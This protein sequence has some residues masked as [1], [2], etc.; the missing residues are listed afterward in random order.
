MR[1]GQVELFPSDIFMGKRVVENKLQTLETHFKD[2]KSSL[3][4]LTRKFEQQAENLENQ[5]SQD[6]MW[7]SA[8]EDSGLSSAETDLLLSYACETLVTLRCLV[9]A[10]LPD[11]AQGLATTAAILR[12]KAR[13][14]R[15]QAAWDAALRRLEL[16]EG[17]IAALGAFLAAHGHEAQ[18]CAAAPGRWQRPGE[19]AA[20]ALCRAVRNERLRDGLLRA[21][22]AVEEERTRRRAE[23]TAPSGR[24]ERAGGKTAPPP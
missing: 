24:S 12:R 3:D 8:L 23:S 16:R 5:R 2:V 19:A 7:T 14:S 9:T 22:K 21:V 1:L 6:A 4:K 15:I 18:R 13:H 10:T 20:A 11:L 17:D